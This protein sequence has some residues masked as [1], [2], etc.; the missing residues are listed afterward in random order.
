MASDTLN[1]LVERVPEVAKV[2]EVV[3][4]ALA[5]SAC[6]CGLFGWKLS[7]SRSRRSP[8]KSAALSSEEPK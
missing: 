1:N 8:A 7:M 5:G 3:D 4:E 6:S 2:V